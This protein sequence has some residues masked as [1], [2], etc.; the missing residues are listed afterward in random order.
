MQERLT[1]WRKKI[2]A[3]LI[4]DASK[5]NQMIGKQQQAIYSE[6]IQ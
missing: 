2:L 1:G 5:T 4:K 3:N 6:P